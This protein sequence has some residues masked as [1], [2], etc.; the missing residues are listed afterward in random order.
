M[1]RELNEAVGPRHAA[2]PAGTREPRAD[3]EQRVR[4]KRTSVDYSDRKKLGF[5]VSGAD[6]ENYT[7]RWVMGTAARVER[8]CL[9]DDY[10]L[11]PDMADDLARRNLAPTTAGK[12]L[13]QILMRKPRDWNEED[14]VAKDER[15]DEMVRAIEGGAP[16]KAT[17]GVENAYIPLDPI[18]RRPRRNRLEA[19]DG[20]SD[21]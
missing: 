9:R 18:T 19:R 11:V 17:P 12:E 1:G 4:R 8:L 3:G 15:R 7:Y 6:L 5:D 2:P 10:E 14:Q 13:Q 20:D 16:T 21:A